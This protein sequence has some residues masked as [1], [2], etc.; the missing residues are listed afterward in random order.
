M[1]GGLKAWDVIEGVIGGERTFRT[2]AM[3]AEA[4]YARCH[5]SCR[6]GAITRTLSNRSVAERV[7][8][9]SI[10]AQEVRICW[11]NGYKSIADT[12]TRD[13]ETARG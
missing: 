9:C 4:A 1:D 5:E 7:V 11:Q 2:V 12:W 10:V 13:C 3:I 6:W 8:N